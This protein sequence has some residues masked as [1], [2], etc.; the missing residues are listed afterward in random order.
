[1]GTLK[2]SWDHDR[3]PLAALRRGEPALFEEFV[4]TEVGALIGF[5]MRLGAD[6][7]DAEDLTQDVCL[8]L[9]RTAATYEAR[10]AFGAYLS[11]LAR[12][13]WID[14]KRRGAARPRPR[15]IHGPD[16]SGAS[17]G[18]TVGLEAELPAEVP[19][20]GRAM[21]AREEA[22]RCLAALSQLSPGHR[23]VFELAVIQERPYAEI[24]SEL[25]IPVGTVKSRVFHAVRRLRAELSTDEAPSAPARDARGEPR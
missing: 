9:Y 6:R 17:G 13:A 14:R 23:M 11:R 18:R 19:E 16:P 12:N 15:S 3:D 7:T 20:P 8:K 22:R 5:F 4:R 1:M 10:S 21:G 2:G 24:A 25:G